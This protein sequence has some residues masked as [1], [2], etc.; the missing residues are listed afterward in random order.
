MYTGLFCISSLN[1][2]ENASHTLHINAPQVLIQK[3][4]EYVKRDPYTYV[5]IDLYTASH[6]LHINAPQV[7]HICLEGCI[8]L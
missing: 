3:S 1:R 5:K 4:P 7:R 6:T 2:D 8:V